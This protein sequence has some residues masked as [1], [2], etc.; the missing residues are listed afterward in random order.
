M[1]PTGACWMPKLT[2]VMDAPATVTGVVPLAVPSGVVPRPS[3]VLF[4]P[5]GRLAAGAG[6][7]ATTPAVLDRTTL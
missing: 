2:L 3:P 7:P 5:V 6:L 1:A 4:Q